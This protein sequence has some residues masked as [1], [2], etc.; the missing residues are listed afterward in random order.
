[1]REKSKT[2]NSIINTKNQL[3]QA[4]TQLNHIEN[5]NELKDLL[6]KQKYMQEEIKNL[7]ED[8]ES[9]EQSILKAEKDIKDY[10][11][12]LDKSLIDFYEDVKKRVK[13]VFV[14]TDMKACSYCGTILPIDLYNRLI[15]NNIPSFMCPNCQR[16]I[17][18]QS[19]I[20]K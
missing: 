10:K 7:K 9:I 2:E 15:Q 12:T 1:L 18:K 16:I 17:Y 8:L 13:P 11:N 14:P 6:S 20:I 5:S 3:K 19:D 4:Y